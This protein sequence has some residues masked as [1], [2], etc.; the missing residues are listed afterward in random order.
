MKIIILF[1]SISVALGG[2]VQAEPIQIS[3]HNALKGASV[4]QD[5]SK[6]LPGDKSFA[7][8]TNA[9]I[10]L[11]GSQKI[12]GQVGFK[13]HLKGSKY[14]IP[15]DFLVNT[16]TSFYIGPNCKI[17]HL[18]IQSN[19]NF[20]YGYDTALFHISWYLFEKSVEEKVIRTITEEVNSINDPQIKMLCGHGF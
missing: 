19:T 8:I 11:D 13:L 9:A 4:D 1:A 14:L 20:G 6:A 10:T 7:E 17:T 16:N 15:Y 12:L 5:I 3:L 18:D 2:A